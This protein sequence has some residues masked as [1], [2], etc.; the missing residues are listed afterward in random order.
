MLLQ[1]CGWPSELELVL[2][3]T[4]V[5]SDAGVHAVFFVVLWSVQT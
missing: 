5:R 4:P 2:Y 3:S 1:V